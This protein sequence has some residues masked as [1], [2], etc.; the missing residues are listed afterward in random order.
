MGSISAL[1]RLQER[2]RE[3]VSEQVPSS[4]ERRAASDTVAKMD[5][6]QLVASY[7]HLAD[8]D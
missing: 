1:L 7:P 3:H 2:V 4:E 5:Y 6:P 8:E